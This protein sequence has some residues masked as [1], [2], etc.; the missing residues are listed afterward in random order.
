MTRAGREGEQIITLAQTASRT[1]PQRLHH[2]HRWQ[3]LADQHR[4]VRPTARHH[5]LT[6]QLDTWRVAVLHAAS[7]ALRLLQRPS[8]RR[9]QQ[10]FKWRR[11]RCCSIVILPAC[12][13]L[14][15]WCTECPLWRLWVVCMPLA[16]ASRVL[17]LA[18]APLALGVTPRQKVRHWIALLVP[19]HAHHNSAL[20]TCA[21]RDLPEEHDQDTGAAQHCCQRV[22]SPTSG[23]HRRAAT[24]SQ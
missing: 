1:L 10:A 7:S 24:R 3:E 16:L 22:D 2:S 20:R 14:G 8:L 23:V 12:C 5:A 19:E 18:A 11:D 4:D 17:V 15:G 6:T 21:E 9:H 13:L